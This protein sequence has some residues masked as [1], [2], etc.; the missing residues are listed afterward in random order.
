[1]T[2]SNTAYQ[3][4]VTGGSGYQSLY[5]QERRDLDSLDVRKETFIFYPQSSI[6]TADI[7]AAGFHYTGEGHVIRCFCCKLTV[8]RL[9][10]GEDPLAVH[11]RRAPNCQFVRRTVTPGAVSAA[12]PERQRAEDSLDGLGLNSDSFLPSDVEEDGEDGGALKEGLV[13]RGVTKQDAIAKPLRPAAPVGKSKSFY[14][15]SGA[16]VV[17]DAW[18]VSIVPQTFYSWL[19][20]DAGFFTAL[21]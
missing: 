12:K 19:T 15:R 16:T 7:A 9:S 2:L 21:S 17:W 11:R 8:T 10:D 3:T 5:S 6:R 18:D 14:R 4:S 20:P 1:M 13:A